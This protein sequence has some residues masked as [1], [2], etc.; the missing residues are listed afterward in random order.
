MMMM[1]MMM[2]M[3]GSYKYEDGDDDGDDVT[4]NTMRWN[5]YSWRFINDFRW[6]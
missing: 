5:H 1:M 4:Y 3:I 2:M 6:T